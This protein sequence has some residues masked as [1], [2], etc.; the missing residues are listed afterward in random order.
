[1][2]GAPAVTLNTAPVAI[3]P[4]FVTR[5]MFRRPIEALEPMLIDMLTPVGFALTSRTVIA[6]SFTPPI[7]NWT[8]VTLVKE[9]PDRLITTTD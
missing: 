2:T 7:W 5:T 8:P 4:L 3:L 1:M 6:V 9:L